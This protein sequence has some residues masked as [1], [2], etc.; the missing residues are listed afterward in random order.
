MTNSSRISIQQDVVVHDSMR[1]CACLE[2]N[3]IVTGLISE[4]DLNPSLSIN[5][6]LALP[7]RVSRVFM[8]KIYGRC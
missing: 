8:T 7:L 4:S 3:N 6:S 1:L 5:S 2:P